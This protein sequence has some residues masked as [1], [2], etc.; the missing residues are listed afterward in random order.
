MAGVLQ[1][2]GPSAR[3]L[4]RGHNFRL[5]PLSSY[6]LANRARRRLVFLQALTR[7]VHALPLSDKF[8]ARRAQSSSGDFLLGL[9]EP[10]TGLEVLT[11]TSL[12]ARGLRVATSLLLLQGREQ[13]FRGFHSSLR[14]HH[15]PLRGFARREFRAPRASKAGKALLEL[16]Q[17]YLLRA[18]ELGVLLSCDLLRDC[19]RLGL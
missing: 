19:P 6:R 3:V 7:R 4:G 16:L 12:E 14:L 11:E 10:E 17:F 2:N 18:D 13:T 9:Q 15:P 1:S 8:L 5:G